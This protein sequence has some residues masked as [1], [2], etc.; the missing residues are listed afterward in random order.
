MK[1]IYV[2]EEVKKQH[3]ARLYNMMSVKGVADRISFEVNPSVKLPEEKKLHIFFEWDAW[4]KMQALVKCCEKEIGFYGIVDRAENHRD[5]VISDIFVCPQIVTGTTVNTDDEEFSMWN[6]KL[7]DEK[8]ED[9]INKR[10]FYGHSHV[11][12]GCSPSGVDTT[13]Y[14][15]LLNTHDD[16][17]IFGIFN[18]RG[19]YWFQVADIENNIYYEKEDIVYENVVNNQ[20]EWAKA[21]IAEKVKVYSYASQ[22]RSATGNYPY[23]GGYGG[24]GAQSNYGGSKGYN[25]DKK[26]D[27]ES[28]T[29]ASAYDPVEDFYGGYLEQRGYSY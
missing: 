1:H 25:Y 15:D 29:K 18:K 20:E 28:K 9:Y 11:N 3:M 7:Y 5:F 27:E 2:T 13:Q 23:F 8:G 14:D 16:F 26:K 17:Y 4:E 12:M 22:N 10:R 6:E 24:Y 21:E 19:D